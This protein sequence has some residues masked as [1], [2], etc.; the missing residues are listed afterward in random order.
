VACEGIPPSLQPDAGLHLSPGPL[1]VCGG[2]TIRQ[3]GPV[4]LHRYNHGL[5][6]CN[7]SPSRSYHYVTF[8][9][10]TPHF[11][12][13]A[14]HDT[15]LCCVHIT[16]DYVAP[17]FV[18][19]CAPHA[20]KITNLIPHWKGVPSVVSNVYRAALLW[21]VSLTGLYLARAR[22]RVCVCVCVCKKRIVFACAVVSDLGYIFE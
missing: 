22:A 6:R 11:S 8:R 15:S 3:R 14:T 5:Q 12:P 19:L 10:P 7:C 16:T 20:A 9:R 17:S 13:V 1:H 4:P 21:E 2:V 18:V